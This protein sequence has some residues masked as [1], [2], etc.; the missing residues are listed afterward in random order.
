[1]RRFSL[2]AAEQWALLG[3]LLFL[4]SIEAPKNIAAAL[5]LLFWLLNRLR[6]RDW[7]G[8]WSAWET[9]VFA[10]IG[11]AYA[12]AAF[13]AFTPD[14]GLSAGNDVLTYG[15]V[16]LAVRRARYDDK[17][18]WQALAMAIVATL[19][20]LAHG[21]WGLYVT[22]QRKSLGLHSV[23]HV[24]HSAIYMAIVFAAAF[25][26]LLAVWREGGR[27]RWLV[28]AA[29]AALWISLFISEARGAIIP[30][31]GFALLMPFLLLANRSGMRRAAVLVPLALV[32]AVLLAAPKVIEKTRVNSVK[33]TLTSYRPAL[34]RT[35]LL[36]FREHPV[37]GVGITSF[38]R[39][40]PEVA[41]EWQQDNGQWFAPETLFHSSHAHNLFTNTLAERGLVGF[42]PLLAFLGLCA[43]NLVRS[44]KIVLASGGPLGRTLWGSA[45]GA[46]FVTVVGGLFN[47]S[48][49]HE[50]ALITIIFVALWLA[51]ENSRH[52][53]G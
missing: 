5:Y 14:K 7:G 43:V 4:P 15:L 47:T 36:A 50:H 18:M 31:V 8:P 42:L 40:S 35:S 44:R 23:G 2:A 6:T 52:P 37:F 19:L 30:A 1:M 49:H 16:F 33:G 12:S 46:W 34:A 41:A 26:W 24:N 17:F 53:H 32:F 21:Y 51:H 48:L 20:T 22:G 25:A 10:L 28:G 3:V 38:G 11:G 29:V 27:Q 9:T 45:F 39:I 13:G